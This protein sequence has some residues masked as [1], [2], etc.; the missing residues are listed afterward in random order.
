[1]SDLPRYRELPEA[2]KVGGRHA[3]GV[4]G[5]G[6]ELGR[7]NLLTADRVAAAAREV[8]RGAVFNVCLP[9]TL[10]DPPWEGSRS[11]LRHEIFSPD[12]NSQDDRLENFYLQ[13]STQWDG[14][15]HIRARE[16]GFYG[17]RQAEQAGPEGGELGIERWV[18]HGLAGRGVLVDVA[19]ITVEL[20][21]GTLAAQGASLAPGDFL[22]LRTGYVAAYLAAGAEERADFSAQRDCPG[23]HAGE[24]MAEFLWDSGVTAIVADNPAVEVVPGSREAGSLHRRLIPLLGFVLG[25]LFDLEALAE[26]CAADGRYSCLFVGIPLHLPGGVGSPGNSLAFK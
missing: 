4:F 2:E 23:L 16:L 9:L 1:L 22:L 14:L 24:E 25:E 20:L 18:E 8:V 13:A 3:W 26:D 12:R 5:E 6:D 19:P 7:V 15:R 11:Q 10:P 21:Q 17:G